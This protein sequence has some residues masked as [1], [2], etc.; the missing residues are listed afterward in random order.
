MSGD[1]DD[2]NFLSTV[3]NRGLGLHDARR[4]DYPHIDVRVNRP[5]RPEGFDPIKGEFT[6][7]LVFSALQEL[8]SLPNE[9][10]VKMYDEYYKA[11]DS[12]E[13]FAEKLP[14]LDTLRENSVDNLTVSSSSRHQKHIYE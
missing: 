1:E 7:E 10:T 9:I 11:E 12:F 3:L 2:E 8:S 14:G 13:K 5:R 4:V 6:R